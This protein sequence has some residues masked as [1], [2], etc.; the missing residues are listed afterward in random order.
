MMLESFYL[1]KN[2]KA[3]FFST[4]SASESSGCDDFLRKLHLMY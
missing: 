2:K 1:K 3:A 4:R